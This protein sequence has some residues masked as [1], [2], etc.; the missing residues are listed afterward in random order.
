MSRDLRL[1][2][3]P[4]PWQAEDG[5]RAAFASRVARIEADLQGVMGLSLR[6][7]ESGES[8]DV[9]GGE[10]FPM[11]STYKVPIAATLL[12]RVDAGGAALDEQVV[13]TPRHVA[14]TGPVAQSLRHPGVSLSLANLLELM[15]TQSNNNAT[16]RVLE[17]IGGPPAVAAWLAGAGLAGMRVDDN[18]ND[19]LNVFYG[20]PAGGAAEDG[21]LAAYGTRALQEEMSS[22]TQA[23]FEADPRN[24]ATPNAMVEL[25]ARLFDGDLLEPQSRALLTLI[26][27]RCETGARRIR[28]A[29]PPGVTVADKTGTIG[30]VVNDVG[31]IT[32]PDERGR[33]IIAVYTKGSRLTP[34]AVR[35]PFLAEISRAAFEYF[36]LRQDAV[37]RG[38]PKLIC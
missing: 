37:F 2:T 24:A 7:L 5:V 6:H 18:V 3:S 12:A 38:A 8:L 21:F 17:R 26:M 35:E 34:Y 29:L 23:K 27:E 32:L 28:G 20:L 4:T 16:D 10:P 30:G 25:L 22:Q 19:L 14:E 33:L 1:Q 13:I 9:N 11:A 15:L 31:M 36:S